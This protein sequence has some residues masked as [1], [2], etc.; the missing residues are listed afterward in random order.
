M[1]HTV[2]FSFSCENF[3]LNIA[4]SQEKLFFKR[5]RVRFSLHVMFNNNVM[6]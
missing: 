3:G 4:L 6:K 5:V 1:V 2:Y